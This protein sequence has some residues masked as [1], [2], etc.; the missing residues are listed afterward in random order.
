MP[1]SYACVDK[2]QNSQ[3]ADEVRLV[4]SYVPQK[5][6]LGDEWVKARQ[7]A[8]TC[9]NYFPFGAEWKIDGKPVM[10]CVSCLWA[11]MERCSVW[12]LKRTTPKK[13]RKT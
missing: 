2:Q 12:A 5:L 13:A 11:R 8:N 9:N 6:S 7:L 3:L 1:A 4:I 10:S